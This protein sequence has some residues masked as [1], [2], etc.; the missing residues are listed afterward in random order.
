LEK[1]K[2][3]QRKN[4]QRDE[5]CLLIFGGAG[6]DTFNR[7]TNIQ[8]ELREGIMAMAMA[9]AGGLVSRQ[10]PNDGDF[11]VVDDRNDFWW[12]RVRYYSALLC[13]KLT[14]TDRTNS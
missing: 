5:F 6:Y 9:M 11:V 2:V 14:F 8:A 3:N 7:P 13:T 1:D 4:E 10:N 12:T